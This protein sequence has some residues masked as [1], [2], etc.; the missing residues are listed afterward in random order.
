MTNAQADS[1][2]ALRSSRVIAAEGQG[3]FSESAGWGMFSVPLLEFVSGNLRK[4]LFLLLAAVF[5]VLLIACANIAG[6]SWPASGKQREVSIQIA[7]GVSRSRLIR[8]AFLE[9]LVLAVA[10]VVLGLVIAWAAIPLLLMLAPA[11]L[12]QNMTIHMGWPI[13]FLQRAPERPACS[14]AVSRRRGR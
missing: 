12:A 9:S 6:C 4:P 5:S 11:A 7:L 2:L 3:G 8:N 1:Y 13:C 10:G 14:S